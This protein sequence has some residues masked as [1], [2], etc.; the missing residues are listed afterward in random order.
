MRS[1]WLVHLRREFPTVAFKASTQSQRSHL[2]RSADLAMDAAPEV[3]TGSRCVPAWCRLP[4]P[5]PRAI[6]ACL[7]H[8][9]LRPP[10]SCVGADAL[11]QLL[12]NYSRR[13]DMKTAITVG[14]VGYPNVGKSR[15]A[16]CS[17]PAPAS[18]AT[19]TMP[20]RSVINSLKRSKAAGVSSMPGFTRSLQV[21][22]P[23]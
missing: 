8:V 22:A 14:V 17:T 2:G 7:A 4:S 11:M 13:D 3:L 19:L 23:A 6:T 1:Q 16:P 20:P 21:R 9:H 18:A 10:H 5:A 15:C 12:K